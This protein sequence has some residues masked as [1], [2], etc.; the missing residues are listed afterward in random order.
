MSTPTLEDIETAHIKA[1]A[2]QAAVAQLIEAYKAIRSRIV[3]LLSC[4]IELKDGERYAGAILN[5]DGTIKH[6]V[7]L[8]PEEHQDEWE[9]SKAW[10]AERGG[11]LPDR[12]EQ[13]LLMANLGD[14]FGAF[15]YWSSEAYDERSAWFQTFFTGYQDTTD[16]SAQLRALAV[17]RVSP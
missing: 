15:A 14:E 13:R 6:H 1:T 2:A 9:D 5:A 8:L 7:I 4:D 16:K 11:S 17:R 3:S 10:A 12:R